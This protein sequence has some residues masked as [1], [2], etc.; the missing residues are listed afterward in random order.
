M[1]TYVHACVCMHVS[2]CGCTCEWVHACMK[3]YM[4]VCMIL[5]SLFL[6]LVTCSIVRP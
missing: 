3:V 6:S 4:H 2:V 5:F 1:Y